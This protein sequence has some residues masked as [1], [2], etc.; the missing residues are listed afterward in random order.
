MTNATASNN[1]N[2]GGQQMEMTLTSISVFYLM[3]SIV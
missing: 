3:S 2:P 1:N